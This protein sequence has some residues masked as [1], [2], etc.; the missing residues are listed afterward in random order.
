[1]GTI[2]DLRSPIAMTGL[3][4]HCDSSH[5]LGV[6][7]HTT[8]AGVLIPNLSRITHQAALEIR[9]GGQTHVCAAEKTLYHHAIHNPPARHGQYNA[10]MDNDTSMTTSAPQFTKSAP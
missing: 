5:S 3:L 8:L 9:Q 4:A 2:P 7:I 10:A 6:Q 1:M